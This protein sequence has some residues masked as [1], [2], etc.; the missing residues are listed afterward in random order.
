MCKLNFKIRMATVEAYI[1]VT[2]GVDARYYLQIRFLRPQRGGSKNN[3][4]QV[5]NLILGQIVLRF[6]MDSVYSI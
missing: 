4:G 5:Q 1:E 3:T 2:I 6:L